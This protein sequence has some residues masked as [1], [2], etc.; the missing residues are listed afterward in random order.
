MAFYDST[1][2]YEDGSH[3]DEAAAP[4][5]RRRM[6]KVA[7]NIRNLTD[8]Q[9]LAKLKT[10][11][12]ALT[13]HAADFPTPNP[14]L[15]AGLA[16]HDAAKAKIDAIEMKEQEL[17]MMRS[18]RDALMAAAMQVY[19]DWGAFVENKAGGLASRIQEG[20]FDVVGAPQA[21]QPMPK[22]EALAFR[23]G[24]DEGKGDATW[25]SLAGAKSYEVQLSPD[26]I[27]GSSFAHY[28]VV[29]KSKASV[30]GQPSGQ[31]RWMRVRAVGA[32]GPGPWSDPACC[33]IP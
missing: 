27:T 9:K 29:T 19:S 7:L 8:L 32:L 1:A 26:P 30:S 23:S 3:Y 25:T 10:A 22:V 24:D 31:K 15:A 17:E 21:P 28:S 14:T 18:E 16:A 11:H 12:T 2:H 20:G 13:D 6:A 4:P 5:L 33:M